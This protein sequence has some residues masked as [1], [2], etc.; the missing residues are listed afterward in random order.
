MAALISR[1]ERHII[2]LIIV[3]LA[4][5]AFYAP[6]SVFAIYSAILVFRCH[7]LRRAIMML[8]AFAI[9][10]ICRHFRRAFSPHAIPI[11]R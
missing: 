8:Y 10:Y 5:D 7:L 9:I 2:T 11:L 6:L 1:F 4:E 3:M